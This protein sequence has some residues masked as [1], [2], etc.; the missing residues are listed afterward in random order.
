MSQEESYLKGDWLRMLMKDFD[1]IQE[2][3]DEDNIRSTP[4]EIYRKYIRN[5][6]VKGLLNITCSLKKKQEENELP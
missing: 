5:K 3:I 4:K 6:V 2:Q 1:F